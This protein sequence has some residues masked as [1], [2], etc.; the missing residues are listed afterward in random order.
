MLIV[1][2]PHD[3]VFCLMPQWF[4]RPKTRTQN[5]QLI[6]TLCAHHLWLTTRGP[7]SSIHLG[8]PACSSRGSPLLKDLNTPGLSAVMSQP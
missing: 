8:L 7:E 6:S 4:C 5:P 2:S 1:Q 3:L